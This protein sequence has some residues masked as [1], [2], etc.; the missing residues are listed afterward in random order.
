MVTPSHNPIRPSRS[1]L[2]H[3]TR[4]ALP[5]GGR[6]RVRVRQ[7]ERTGPGGAF[8]RPS[9]VVRGS[10]KAAT[11]IQILVL[12]IPVIFA[13]MGFAVDLG[14]LYMARAELKTAAN[15]MA[16]AAASELI[17]TATATDAATTAYVL[18]VTEANGVANKYDFGGLTIGE[19]NGTLAGEL[20]E[21]EFY[22]TVSA[23]L[24]SGESPGSQAAG[25]DTARHVRVTVSAEAPL[26]FWKILPFLTGQNA[27]LRSEA[28]AGV[29]A[30]LCTACGI[31]SVAV[32][33]LDE[34]DTTDFGFIPGTR[35]TLGYNC[36]GNGAPGPLV[37]TTQRIPYLLANKYNEND[38]V[39][40][41]QNTQTFRIGGAGLPAN[42]TS[43][44]ACLQVN[45]VESGWA[46]TTALTCQNV[47]VPGQ[48][49]GFM[50]G[51][52]TRF[53]SGIPNGCDNITSIDTAGGA[54]QPDSDVEDRE[55]YEEYTGNR[56]RVITVAVVDA[57][58]SGEA[59]TVLGFRQF[60]LEPNINTTEL[61]AT[62]TG[63][64]FAALYI[65]SRM[66]LRGGSI[67]GCSI[68]SGPGKVVLHR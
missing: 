39:F 15:A 27:T 60:L 38:L 53:V 42:S 64:R 28:I 17:G 11:S 3:G 10:E 19:T 47:R 36:Q 65:G 52:A 18:S 66:P 55:T 8:R 5:F 4:L 41:D 1:L 61:D 44:L 12:L 20:P 57:L 33:P 31:E 22:E 58:G 50:C 30:P 68:A 6:T 7:P 54:Y 14:R 37:G 62:D 26:T 43:T 13:F 24:E 21:P 67:A 45:A 34:T 32:A 16:L 9:S 59:M 51:L 35:Y 2:A 40:T 49:L 56:R 23:A 25:S 48:V 46:E 63:G 29:S